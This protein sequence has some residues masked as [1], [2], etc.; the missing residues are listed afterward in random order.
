MNSINI[1]KFAV[2]SALCSD[3]TIKFC[4]GISEIFVCVLL[5]IVHEIDQSH[6]AIRWKYNS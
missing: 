2:F 5:S 1:I 4:V 3:F 6:N